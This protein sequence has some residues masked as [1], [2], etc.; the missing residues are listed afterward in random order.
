MTHTSLAA[1]ANSRGLMHDWS[2][3]SGA[4]KDTA[5]DMLGTVQEQEM[6]TPLLQY[7]EGLASLDP[8]PYI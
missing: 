4:V 3:S 2:L 7:H 8:F 5:S 6:M 1:V